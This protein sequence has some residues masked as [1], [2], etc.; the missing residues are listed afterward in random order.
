MQKFTSTLL[1]LTIHCLAFSQVMFNEFHYDNLN[2]DSL[3]RIEIV[4]LT[5]TDM[6][7]W[8]IYMYNG[9]DSKVY[10]SFPLSGVLGNNCTVGGQSLGVQVYEVFTITNLA[11]QNGPNDGMALVK[12]GAVVEFLSYEGTLTAADGPAMGMTSTD[13]GAVEPPEAGS[14]SSLQRNADNTWTFANGANTFGACNASQGGV[15]LV[16]VFG[17]D[18]RDASVRISPNPSKGF[19]QIEYTAEK[20][21]T[22]QVALSG[23]EGRVVF[24]SSENVVLGVNVLTFDWSDLPRGLYFIQLQNGKSSRVKKIVLE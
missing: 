17:P 5:G 16:S 18:P 10:S 7:G 20:A 4:G 1:F 9:S 19:A 21:E 22:I 3:E 11:F 8:E 6:S 12:N 23:A 2:A 14:M 15:M 24:Q 13:C